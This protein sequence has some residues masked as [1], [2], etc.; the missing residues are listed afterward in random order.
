MLE[1]KRQSEGIERV[2]VS[3]DQERAQS[4][5]S[6]HSKNRSRRKTKL[7]IS[8]IITRGLCISLVEALNLSLK[9]LKMIGHATGSTRLAYRF[10]ALRNR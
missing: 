2:H 9:V 4:E 7:T 10:G 5:R 8:N 6:S 3:N 1:V